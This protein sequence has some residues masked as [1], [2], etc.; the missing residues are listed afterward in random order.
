MTSTSNT[1]TTH[2]R[3]VPIPNIVLIMRTRLSLGLHMVSVVDTSEVDR[4]SV[5]TMCHDTERQSFEHRVILLIPLLQFIKTSDLKTLV[6]F[7]R[8]VDFTQQV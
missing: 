8:A 5:V 2:L 1:D 7:E 4:Y 6:A 3:I